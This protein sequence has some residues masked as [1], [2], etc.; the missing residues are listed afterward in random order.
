MKSNILKNIVIFVGILTSVFSCRVADLETDNV[1]M[2]KMLRPVSLVASPVSSE[3]IR[4][5]WK[6]TAGSVVI[7][8]SPVADL[9][10]K[11]TSL[12]VDAVGTYDV[13][14][15]DEGT[16]YYFR[17]KALADKADKED[18]EFSDICYARTPLEP[19]IPNVN[20][21][22][23]MEYELDPWSVT[24]T[25]V[26]TW[27]R[28]NNETEH[29][30]TVR[31][32]PAPEGEILTF[33]LSEDDCSN[34]AVTLSE[35]IKTDTQYTIE[36]LNGSKI[37]GSAVHKT[38]QGPIPSMT[39]NAR[40][41]F[42]TDP[43]SADAE[44]TWML[45]YEPAD[46]LKELVM[47]KGE[48]ETVVPVTAENK[49]AGGMTV[50]GLETSAAYR[51]ILKNNEGRVIAETEITTP[52]AP[53]EEMQ[54]VRPTD[55]LAAILSDP[56]RKEIMYLVP[57][58]YEINLSETRVSI[59]KSLEIVSDSPY[60]TSL[61]M[62]GNFTGKGTI[63]NIIFRNISISCSGYFL[64]IKTDSYEIDLLNF[65]NCILDLNS[66]STTA[67]TLLSV[68]GTSSQVL[69]ELKINNSIVYSNSAQA[70]GILYN[71]ASGSKAELRK[72]TLTNSTFANTGRGLIATSCTEDYVYDI[73]VE[74]CT[75]YGLQTAS[76]VAIIDIRYTGTN[77]SAQS[78]IRFNNSV[79]WFGKTYYKLLQLGSG[80]GDIAASTNL[81]TFQNQVCTSPKGLTPV[82]YQGN[83]ADF[84]MNPGL[85]PTSE[86]VSFKLKDNSLRSLWENDGVYVGD[87]NWETK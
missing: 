53:S 70:Q 29:L 48:Q 38:V 25:L 77:C 58:E 65:E 81:Y 15:L 78:R 32:T 66:S 55:D 87:P 28:L 7:E 69:K 75:M 30:T 11:V 45:Y 74:N 34:L 41:N 67:S 12:E 5:E 21:S 54:I 39:G 2:G 9:S 59:E 49:A 63:G 35:G 3:C 85:N 46:E 76:S 13:K 31:L 42:E 20:A 62:T 16:V 19:R 79:I 18:S 57:G 84:W 43:V 8:Y 80:V 73:L 72:V 1:N 61:R 82:T 86:G 6:S 4:L 24:V 14:D 64:Q 83:P 33:D 36:L 37:R 52:D 71:T 51:A 40:L 17:I 68:S 44:F 56:D 47:V 23:S 22:S 26:L 60:T 27:D 10:D 50:S